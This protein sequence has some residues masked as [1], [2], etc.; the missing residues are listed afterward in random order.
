VNSHILQPTQ[1]MAVN[2]PIRVQKPM[3]RLIEECNM[4]FA[5]RCAKEVDCRVGL[6]AYTEAIVFGDRWK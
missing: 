5:L 1:P 2:R 4:S 3:R 6:S